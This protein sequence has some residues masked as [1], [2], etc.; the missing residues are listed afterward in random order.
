M[1]AGRVVMTVALAAEPTALEMCEWLADAHLLG[2]DDLTNAEVA[3][4]FKVFSRID[5]S[6]RAWRDVNSQRLELLHLEAS[7]E[8]SQNDIRYVYVPDFPFKM[9]VVQDHQ[10]GRS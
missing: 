2:D 3:H 7:L 6:D 1:L 8:A 9:E 5:V 10:F 4:H